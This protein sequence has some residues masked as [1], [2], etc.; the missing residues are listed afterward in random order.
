MP[1]NSFLFGSIWGWRFYESVSLSFRALGIPPKTHGMPRKSEPGFLEQ[2]SEL[3]PGSLQMNGFFL[4]VTVNA[5][6]EDSRKNMTC[7]PRKL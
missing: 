4:Q 7:G 5:F 1:G 6:R 2:L 3:G